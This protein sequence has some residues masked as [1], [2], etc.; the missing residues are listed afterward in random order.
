[1]VAIRNEFPEAKIIFLDDVR[2]G[3]PG[4]NEAGRPGLLA[5]D[6]VG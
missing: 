6:G 2:G 4:R 5:K 3:R 1:M